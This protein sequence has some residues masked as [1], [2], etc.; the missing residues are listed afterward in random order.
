MRLPGLGYVNAFGLV[1]LLNLTLFLQQFGS[2][3]KGNVLK[4][5]Q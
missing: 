2:T 3:K 5:H 1:L 4:C